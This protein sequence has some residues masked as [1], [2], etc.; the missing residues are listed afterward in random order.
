VKGQF[1]RKVANKMGINSL[2]EL[3]GATVVDNKK[4]QVPVTSLGGKGK[5]LGLLFAARWNPQSCGFTQHLVKF[6]ARLKDRLQVVFVS[7]DENVQQWNNLFAKMPW[8]A[9]PFTDQRRLAA[10]S[11]KFDVKA[12][13]T[14]VLIDASTLLTLHED[15]S[16]MVVQDP[17]GE[18]F[19]WSS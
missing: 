3:L 12:L 8:L 11:Q 16:D 18:K 5:V 17:S 13:P 7:S 4:Q 15:A 14:L 2:D 1:V 19:P 6:Q 9:V 10:L